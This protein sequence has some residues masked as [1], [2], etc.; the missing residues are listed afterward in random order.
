MAILIKYLPKALACS[1]AV[2]SVYSILRGSSS[3]FLTPDNLNY[4][5]DLRERYDEWR[6]FQQ[7]IY[8]AEELADLQAKS[9][10]YFRTTVYLPWALP[11]FALLFVPGGFLQGK[12]LIWTG[13]MVSL[14]LISIICRKCL[15]P[16]GREAGLIG[17]LAPLA[18]ANNNLCLS[19]SQFTIIC[20]GLVSLQWVNI[21][22]NRPV[23]AG[24]Y[25][26]MAMVKPQ[27]AIFFAIPLMKRNRLSG[28]AIG[29]GALLTLSILALAIT[30]TSPL[31]MLSS[32]L[33]TLS[34]FVDTGTN[35]TLALLISITPRIPGHF[36]WTIIVTTSI[37]ALALANRLIVQAERSADCN[38]WDLA[39]LCAI[40]GYISV[41]HRVYDHIMLFPALLACLRGAYKNT[42][43]LSIL[44]CISMATT[45]WLPQRF[46]NLIP[47]SDNLVTL[48]LAAI[49]VAL[50]CRINSSK[51]LPNHQG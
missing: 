49:G 50:L 5:N 44:L 9:L 30:A 46:W 4:L 7:G 37:A 43:Y 38:P 20:M 45:V 18:I 14:F 3:L 11:M 1:L 13:S 24:L 23:I 48:I 21:K 36:L 47:N 19:V 39:G 22:E 2:A 40:V 32:W 33:G 12:L 27:I 28:L 8:P 17:A 31:A 42:N 15:L 35:N 41:Y 16:W 51:S 29:S 25:W 26:A 10:S 34:K 6:L